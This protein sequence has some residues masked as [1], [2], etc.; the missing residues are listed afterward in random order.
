MNRRPDHRTV[1]KHVPEVLNAGRK[2]HLGMLHALVVCG[3]ARKC[4]ISSS[5]L[6]QVIINNKDI[7]AL[8]HPLFTDRTARIW[9]DILQWCKFG[10]CCCNNNCIIHGSEGF[11][12]VYNR[13]YCR[14]FLT[15]CNID[16]KDILSFLIDNRIKG[17]GCL[18]SL[19]VTDDQLTLTTA[20]RIMAS[21]A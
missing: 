12:C 8:L 3:E 10:C 4:T 20:N 13:R 2:R 18:T 7:L 11:Q 5:M 9:R 15:N 17:N 1:W 21:I 6:C 19:S 14:L 16:T